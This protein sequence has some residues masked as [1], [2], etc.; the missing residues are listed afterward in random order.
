MEQAAAIEFNELAVDLSDGSLGDSSEESDSVSIESTAEVLMADKSEHRV[1]PGYLEP[2]GD[3]AAASH[4]NTNGGIPGH[5]PYVSQAR[6]REQPDELRHRNDQLLN[7]PIMGTTPEALAM[8]STRLATLAE[9]DRLERLQRELDECE[10]RQPSSSRHKH[11]L[12]SSDQ[13]RKYQ[14][15]STPLKNLA[16]ATRIAD[17]IQPSGSTAVEGIRK[18]QALL[19]TALSQNAAVSQSRDQI[20]SASVRAETIQSSHSP[21]GSGRRRAT[22]SSRDR[23]EDRRRDLVASP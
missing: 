2:K 6:T 17:S 20:H 22:S 19:K 15:L 8:E 10:R 4:I 14:V 16:A 9:R 21:L 12:Y 13:P 3:H 5:E 23:H 7:T 11:R 1:P 18:I